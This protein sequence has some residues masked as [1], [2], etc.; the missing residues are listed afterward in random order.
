L[1]ASHLRENAFPPWLLPFFEGFNPNSKTEGSNR[2]QVSG[3][4]ESVDA[5]RDASKAATLIKRATARRKK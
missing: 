2:P 1:T 3:V 5:S 4:K